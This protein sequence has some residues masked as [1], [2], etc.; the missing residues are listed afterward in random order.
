MTWLPRFNSVAQQNCCQQQLWGG[1]SIIYTTRISFYT[2]QT[3][4]Y[5]I[6]VP[7]YVLIYH[8]SFKVQAQ[9][10]GICTE[11]YIYL[12]SRKVHYRFSRA[13]KK[14]FTHDHLINIFYI[15]ISLLD[16]SIRWC[17]FI[18]VAIYCKLVYSIAILSLFIIIQALFLMCYLWHLCFHS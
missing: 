6:K 8:A 11:E 14:Q 5:K 13:Y 3:L 12:K 17:V 4:K 7:S 16:N 1:V 10:T 9:S 15:G 2:T 18:I